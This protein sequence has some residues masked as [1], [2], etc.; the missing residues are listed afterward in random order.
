VY[1]GYA[2]GNDIFQN[3]LA[4]NTR[5]SP[6]A[7]V[8]DHDVYFSMDNGGPP[9][10]G[11][12][13]ISNLIVPT[14]GKTAVVLF[15]PG[16]GTVPLKNPG[17]D[18]ASYVF[19][20]L[21]GP[22]P[23]FVS[24]VPTGT[25]TAAAAI[26]GYQLTPTSPGIG[27]GTFLTTVTATGNSASLPV[28]DAGF[29]TDG[30]GIVPGDLVRLQGSSQPVQIT[31]VDYAANIITL[32]QSVAFSAGQGLSINYQGAAPDIGLGTTRVPSPPQGVRL[33]N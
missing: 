26:A 12:S 2:R 11:S 31:H 5:S 16:G 25:K 3:N 33:G 21:V 1:K 9:T 22:V 4:V 7:S 15:Y 24:S 18:V 8:F 20:N 14:A 13:V 10:A 32:A 6:S 27:Q 23:Q 17:S 28:K 30:F 29:F 19:G